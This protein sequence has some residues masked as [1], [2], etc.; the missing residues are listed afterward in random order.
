ERCKGLVCLRLITCC[1]NFACAGSVSQLC[2]SRTVSERQL[3]TFL[4]T[5]DEDV[6]V[7]SLKF[8]CIFI[9]GED[10]RSTLGRFVIIIW[11]FVVLIIQS[12]YTASL[13]SILTVQQLISPITGIDSLV[14]SDDPIGFQVGSFAESYLVNELGVSRHRLKSLGTPDE[15]KQA[16]ELGPANGGV[17]AIVDERPYV[18]IFLLLH[19]KFAVVGSEFTKSGWG[20]VSL[21][22][23]FFPPSENNST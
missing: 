12:S 4:H 15:Y 1:V 3:L 14:A 18:E 11:L 17:T 9:L 23:Y 16:L 19:P 8:L 13:T 5:I 2:S 10:T 21:F 7:D 6:P 20:F 22:D